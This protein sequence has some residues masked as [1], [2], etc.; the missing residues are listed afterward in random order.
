MAKRY[1]FIDITKGLLILMVIVAHF[2]L[3]CDVCY[4]IKSPIIDYLP[5]VT[6]LW[7]SF[8]MPAFFFITGYCT[9][10]DKQFKPFII[11]GFKTILLPAIIINS[12]INIIDYST[13]APSVTWAVKTFIKS[14]CLNITGEW[15]LPTLFLARLA[16]WILNKTTD[17]ALIKITVGIVAMIAGVILYNNYDS[18]YNLWY[19]KHMLMVFIFVVLG[20]LFKSIHINHRIIFRNIAICTYIL[21]ITICILTNLS[22]PYIANKSYIP[23]TKIPLLLIMATTGITLILY[24]GQII[25]KNTNRLSIILQYFGKNSLIIYLIHF[26]MYR[27]FIY[28][29]LPIISKNTTIRYSIFIAITLSFV[30]LSTS[31]IAR[32]LNNRRL[33]WILGKF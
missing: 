29:F 2:R 5:K 20:D 15:F 28:L 26:P 1:E 32:L 33:K 12:I 19:F 8:Y 24:I 25:F 9:H 6:N 16:Y 30:V 27:I 7:S 4:G 22:I 31:L 13:Y 23:Y 11:K 14:I 18:I 3:M 10:F 17:N 21:L